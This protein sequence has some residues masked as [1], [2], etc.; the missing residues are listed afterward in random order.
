MLD[1]QDNDGQ[2]RKEARRGEEGGS[3]GSTHAAVL[4][5]ITAVAGRSTIVAVS[6][7]DDHCYDKWLVDY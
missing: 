6:S 4:E 5:Q 2:V 1:D 3:V 7:A